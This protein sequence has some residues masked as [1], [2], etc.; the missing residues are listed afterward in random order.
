MIRF[1]W[2]KKALFVLAEL[3]VLSST[4][5]AQT[6]PTGPPPP[7][8]APPP[9]PQQLIELPAPPVPPPAP[10]TSGLDKGAGLEP[11]AAFP[12]GF[13]PLFNPTVGHA[14]PRLDY[15]ATWFPDEQVVGQPTKLGYLREDL[16]L[17][18][19]IW[20]GDCDE[21]TATASIRNETFH[22][23]AILPDTHQP[24]PD[25]LWNI[26]FGAGYRHLFDNGWI[27]G[28]NVSLG[29]A[30]DQPFHSDNEMIGNVNAFLRIPQGDHNAW[31]FSLAYS[32]TSELPF[33]VPGVAYVWQPSEN[34]RA[35]I[36]LPFML[37]YRPF[38]DLTLDFSYMLLR[39]VHARATYRIAGPVRVYAAFDWSNESYFLVDRPDV[40]DRLFYYDKRLT[41]GLQTPVVKHVF[42]DLSTGYVFDRF[43]FEGRNY[44]DRNFNRIDVGDGP[45]LS[46]QV[47]ARW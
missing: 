28:G 41:A 34:F 42:L 23:Q 35:N 36:G 20:Q 15:R 18:Y 11:A 1:N 12:G 9:P 16:S 26:R 43:Y 31:L 30:S 10:D 24:F 25:D 7:P 5:V 8:S 13:S 32:T 45:F 21:W 4:I 22:T 44:S 29:S 46:L 33:P 2:S 38:D 6:S 39:T 3:A 40:N 14:V 47:L 27:A 37:W 17:S 19:P